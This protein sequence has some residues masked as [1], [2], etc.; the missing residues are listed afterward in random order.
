M[1]RQSANITEKRN[2]GTVPAQK[3]P[4]SPETRAAVARVYSALRIPIVDGEMPP[5]TRIKIDAVARDLGVSQT[6]VRE[7]LQRLESDDLLVYT[8]GRGYRTT[9][10]LDFKGLRSLFEFRLLVE[11]WAARSVATD[12]LS[13]PGP[14][15]AK[16]LAEFE[17][18]ADRDGDVRQMML[19]HD[20]H[21]HDMILAAAG[22]DVV[23]QAYTQTHCHLHVFRLFPVDFDGAIT[24]AEHRTILEAISACDRDAAEIAMADHIRK[25]FERSA[26]AFDERPAEGLSREVPRRIH[27]VR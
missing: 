23:R 15:L 9:P 8:P 14:A 24:I 2:R 21:F 11:P 20:A 5:G 7:A 22:N 1:I 12:R 10:M 17:Q 25:S 27:I 18:I 6:P 26:E 13:N 4:E 16:E 19:A 3:Q